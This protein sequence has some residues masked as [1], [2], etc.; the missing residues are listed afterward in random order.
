MDNF[1][2]RGRVRIF[3][4]VGDKKYLIHDNHNVITYKGREVMSNLMVGATTLSHWSLHIGTGWV[5]M[6]GEP[7]PSITSLYYDVSEADTTVSDGGTSLIY[8][9]HGKSGGSSSATTTDYC[10][11]LLSVDFKGI[12][13]ELSVD[14]LQTFSDSR[15]SDV[16]N[17]FK[18]TCVISGFE[19]GTVDG[20]PINELGLFFNSVAPQDTWYVSQDGTSIMEDSSAI[21]VAYEPIYDA[22]FASSSDKIEV[23]WTISF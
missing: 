16:H 3:N 20:F 14:T 22:V 12:P 6:F 4:I 18:V 7:D 19:N 11:P 13:A 23:E 1:N 2:V 21:M 9:M 8:S 5:G 17:A 15:V 10:Y